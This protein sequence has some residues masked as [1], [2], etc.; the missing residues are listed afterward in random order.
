MKRLYQFYIFF[1]TFADWSKEQ[2]VELIQR[3][4]DNLPDSDQ[5][6]YEYRARKIVWEN[7]CGIIILFVS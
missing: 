6:S 2:D 7:V 3:I 4:K 5:R 1:S